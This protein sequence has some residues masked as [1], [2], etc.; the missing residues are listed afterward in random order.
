MKRKTKIKDTV[1]PTG[2]TQGRHQAISKSIKL[3]SG[4]MVGQGYLEMLSPPLLAQFF[5]NRYFESKIFIDQDAFAS[6]QVR[7]GY[8]SRTISLIKNNPG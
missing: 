1:N 7:E 8:R 3:L 2:D 5:K 6:T 4:K